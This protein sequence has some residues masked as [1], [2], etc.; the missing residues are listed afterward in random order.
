MIDVAEGSDVECA[1]ILEMLFLDL[2]L[3]CHDCARDETVDRYIGCHDQCENCRSGSD[4]EALLMQA[5]VEVVRDEE[6]CVETYQEH[7][8]H[9]AS[10][11][12]VVR[13]GDLVDGHYE[14]CSDCSPEQRILL[15]SRVEKKRPEAELED[16]IFDVVND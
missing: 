12:Q 1:V 6:A 5:A 14:K 10:H 2:D 9:G 16:C 8:R 13:D 15:V 11:D 4:V 7:R 3:V